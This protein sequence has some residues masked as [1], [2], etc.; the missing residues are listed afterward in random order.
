MSLLI[1]DALNIIRRI[2]EAIPEPDSEE[3][4]ADTIKS[5]L[6]SFK[7]ALKT[8]RPTHAVAVF[9]HGGRTWKHELYE[10]YQAHRK[11]MP[12]PLRAGLLTLKHELQGMG[13]PWISIEGIEA[14]DAIA[15]LVE[16]WCI[17][18]SERAIILSTDKDFLQ[19]LNDQVCIYDHFKDVWRD[20]AYVQEK[21]GVTPSQMG[22]L[23]ALMGDAV[24]GVPGVDKIGC[25]TAA[26][27]LRING[28]LD[29]LISNADKVAGQVGVNLRKG[30]DI[31]RL[32]REL[33]S[34]KTDR[35]LGL[36]WKMLVQAQVPPLPTHTLTETLP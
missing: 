10:A 31:A 22:D 15:A 32:S 5:S 7:R 11:P 9:D 14:D 8:H 33:V 35:P 24:D 2:H 20:A 12:Q 29:R 4:V 34:F 27:L 21:F 25:K 6:S 19:L 13:L 30:I 3:K 16:K 36:T 28:N 17:T 26:M 23:L 1:I 18:R